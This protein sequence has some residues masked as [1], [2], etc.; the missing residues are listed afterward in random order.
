[1]ITF[2]EQDQRDFA[3]KQWH[4]T[5]G[6]GHWFRAKIQLSLGLSPWLLILKT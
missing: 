2:S 6:P 3:K 5:E 1:M 4:G